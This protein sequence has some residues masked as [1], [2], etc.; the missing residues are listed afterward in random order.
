M[1]VCR[2]RDLSS[3]EKQEHLKLQRQTEKLNGDLD[4]LRDQR[5]KLTQELRG[6]EKTVDELKEQVSTAS[7]LPSVPLK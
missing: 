3:S 6:S 1:C 4:G 5:D 2:M 7:T